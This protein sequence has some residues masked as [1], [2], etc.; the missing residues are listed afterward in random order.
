MSD[1]T[2]SDF[3][4]EDPFNGRSLSFDGTERFDTLPRDETSPPS[5][6]RLRTVA[7]AHEQA[8]VAEPRADHD[9][10]DADGYDVDG[11]EGV[12]GRE[13][14]EYDRVDDLGVERRRYYATRS[15]GYL[16]DGEDDSSDLGRLHGC[17]RQ[18]RLLERGAHRGRGSPDAGVVQAV[19]CPRRRPRDREKALQREEVGRTVGLEMPGKAKT[20]GSLCRAHSA[21]SQASHKARQNVYVA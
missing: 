14:A 2:R 20:S 21:A 9:R 10:P 18:W 3:W 7:G 4:S 13:G 5:A 16:A 15:D 1:N 6:K 8:A 19:V 12:G 17:A 11:G